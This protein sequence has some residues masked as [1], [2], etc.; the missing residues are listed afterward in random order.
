M[1]EH[2]RDEIVRRI[3]VSGTLRMPG[4]DLAGLDL[5]GLTL[6]GADLSYA[7]L[8]GADL[9]T[10]QLSGASLW[11]SQASQAVF[12][13]AN[14]SG[15]SL[16][17][18]VLVGADLRDCVLDHADLT[19]AQLTGADLTGAQMGGT[20]LEPIQRA[21][22]IGAPP[23]H[24]PGAA[25][26][27]RVLS[28]DG[29]IAP[30]IMRRGDRMELRLNQPARKVHIDQM[31]ANGAAVLTGPEEEAVAD[32]RVLHF[33]AGAPGTARLVISRDE[34]KTDLELDVRVSG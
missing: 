30:V 24:Y 1:T 7:D 15:A 28:E 9:S 32:G 23:L 10:A 18:A 29:A 20:W 4:A 27:P 25:R 13:G 6:V 22:A 33:R 14:M 2:S 17:L 8:T 5:S 21:L 12:R 19:G 31:G 16:G 3:A 11:S 26:P 34:G